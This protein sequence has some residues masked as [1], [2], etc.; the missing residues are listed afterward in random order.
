MPVG[1]ADYSKL[2]N[3]TIIIVAPFDL[4]GEGLFKYTFQMS[5]REVPGLDLHD[6]ATRIF[7]NTQGVSLDGVSQELIDLLHFIEHSDAETAAMSSS[8]KI[9]RIHEKI[10]AIKHSDEVG[11]RFMNA[12]EEKIYERQE[13]KREKTLEIASKM[14]TMGLTMEQ[15]KEATGL[16]ESEIAEL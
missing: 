6:G 5:C 1:E 16:D 7:L 10:E 4:F 9:H 2:N 8:S 13:A 11:V 15:I 3:V 14:K 12:W